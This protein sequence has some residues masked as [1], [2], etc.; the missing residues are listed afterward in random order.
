MWGCAQEHRYLGRP[1]VPQPS[2][3]WTLKAH[4]LKGIL[5]SL[6]P[7]GWIS[8]QNSLA[9]WATFPQGH[10]AAPLLLPRAVLKT[11]FGFFA[12]CPQAKL[13]RLF[14]ILSLFR[15]IHPSE[16]ELRVLAGKPR[17]RGRKDR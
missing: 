5:G 10:P 2:G 16:E 14:L 9:L 12:S 13:S 6:A 1:E 4:R 11:K 15:Y 3:C 17:H 7:C 8:P